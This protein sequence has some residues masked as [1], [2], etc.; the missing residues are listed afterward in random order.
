MRLKQ[1]FHRINGVHFLK[2]LMEIH[3]IIYKN[4][5]LKAAK[6]PHK[7]CLEVSLI[8]ECCTCLEVSLIPECCKKGA[9]EGG[10]PSGQSAGLDVWRLM[11]S[12]C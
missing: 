8:P 7:T 9:G 12:Y 4:I 3:C 1:G 10:P 5:K 6:I 2:S 11:K